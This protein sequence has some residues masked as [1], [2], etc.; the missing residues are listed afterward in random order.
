MDDEIPLYQ[1]TCAFCQRI[2]FVCCRDF[3]AAATQN[4][5]E[6]SGCRCNALEIAEES[7]M[8]GGAPKV[9]LQD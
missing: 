3:H 5:L 4:I 2:F 1:L 7:G 6:F 9:D 8:S